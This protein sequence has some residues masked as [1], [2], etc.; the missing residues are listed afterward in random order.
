MNSSKVANIAYWLISMVAMIVILWFGKNILIPFVLA[1][2]LWYLKRQLRS[3]IGKIKIK[4]KSLPPRLEHTVAFLFIFI[5]LAINVEI[6]YVSIQGIGEAI[7][8]YESNLSVIQQKLDIAF[9]IDSASWLKAHPVDNSIMNL[10]KAI[11]N[12][13]A[14]V[15]GKGLII[16]FYVIFLVLET[17][18]FETKLRAMYQTEGKYNEVIKL[19][20]KLD[21]SLS[22][23]IV[24]KTLVSLLT[25]IL[26]YVVL[27][28]IGVDFA[29]FWAF[30]IFS[31]NYIPTIG[32][33][34]ATVFPT[35]I[36][37]LQGGS[38]SHALFVLAGVGTIQILVGNLVEPKVM[39]NSLNVSS[40]V[41]I[42][43]L[44]LWGSLW[45]IIGMIIA[46]PITVILIIIFAQFPGSRKIAIILSKD[47]IID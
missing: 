15:L 30:L 10:L 6:I 42:L 20:H 41:V 31:L 5:L 46:V 35:V 37:L 1:L 22:K 4:G 47:G 3:L 28:V 43:S 40:L 29:V 14:A 18:V 16:L 13:L 17:K 2:I 33:L 25:G 39:G 27:A 24:L 32:S 44:V 7:P 36:A 11:L 12:S 21:K 19:L 23:Y 9:N 26:S 8:I 38:F 45:G 34:V